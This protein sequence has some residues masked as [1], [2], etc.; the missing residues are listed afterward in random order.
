MTAQGRTVPE[1]LRDDEEP[2]TMMVCPT[3]NGQRACCW[4]CHDGS[5]RATGFVLRDTLELDYP[6]RTA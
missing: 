1:P 4:E 5:G 3:C 6:G 2:D